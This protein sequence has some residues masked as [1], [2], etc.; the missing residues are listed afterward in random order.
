MTKQIHHTTRMHFKREWVGTDAGIEF[1]ADYGQRYRYPH[2]QVLEAV[3]ANG[4][5]KGTDSWEN[6]GV[7]HW[8][9]LSQRNRELLE[10]YRV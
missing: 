5:I 1:E 7:Y 8:P 2:D 4:S 3:M 10:P 6:N 9:S